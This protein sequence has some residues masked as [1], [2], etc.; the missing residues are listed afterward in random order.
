[1]EDPSTAVWRNL[2]TTFEALAAHSPAGTTEQFGAVTAVSAGVPT[3]TFN[4][5]FAFEP[6]EQADLLAAIDW[7]REQ[8]DPFWV[9]ALD[10]LQGD[11]E[12]SLRDLDYKQSETPQPGM[13]RSIS[14]ALPAPD[15][16]AEIDVVTTDAAL[17]DW[18]AVAESVFEF[19]PETTR[20]IT[21]ASVLDD[22]SLQYFVGRVDDDPAACGLLSMDGSVAGVYVIGV[23]EAFR[24]RGIGH[25]MTRALL[26]AGHQ[27]G[28]E[29]GV[30]HSTEMGY[31]LYDQMGF[32][33]T[34]ELRHFALDT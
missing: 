34:V 23:E 31:P 9:T 16:D 29:L 5:V 15:T 14:S 28:A 32:D 11:I 27:R 8:D 26:R 17:A 30:L 2:R 19:A 20:R 3:P 21:P 10:S 6:H 12:A 13:A 1:M 33:T 18:R 25:A 7:F 4:R 24:R 22:E